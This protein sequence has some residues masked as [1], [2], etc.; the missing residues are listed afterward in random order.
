MEVEAHVAL[1]EE[2]IKASNRTTHAVRAL[3]K[4]IVYEAAYALAVTFLAVIALIPTFGLEEPWWWLLFLAGLLAL[5]G[6]IHSFAA[7]FGELSASEITWGVLPKSLHDSASRKNARPTENEEEPSEAEEADV[8]A[9]K[10]RPREARNK[11][12]RLYGIAED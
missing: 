3:T 11:Y 5:G 4:F 12:E 8:A 2:S 6:L 7:A 10:K 1:F 9:F